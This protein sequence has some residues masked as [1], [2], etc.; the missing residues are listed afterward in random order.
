[1]VE[2]GGWRI[3]RGGNID[4]AASGSV[5]DVALERFE[6]IPHIPEYIEKRNMS[7]LKR[8]NEATG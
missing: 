2:S 8:F 1:M 3:K 5:D 4:T 6:K 7:F